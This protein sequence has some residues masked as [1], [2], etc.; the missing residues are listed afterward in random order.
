ME[1]CNLTITRRC[2]VPEKTQARW[3]AGAAATGA[4]LGSSEEWAVINALKAITAPETTIGLDAPEI[5][6]A[7]GVLPP[8]TSHV[9]IWRGNPHWTLNGRETLARYV[10]VPNELGPVLVE[11]YGDAEKMAEI[12]DP[13][14]RSNA[15][16]GGW[17]WPDDGKTFL[18]YA[19]WEREIFVVTD[20][21]GESQRMIGLQE[22]PTAAA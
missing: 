15:M 12:S 3:R 18:A 13:L 11:F 16:L 21:R 19:D 4:A 22:I 2:P 20:L 5:E 6:F 10:F 17:H 8:D 1:R 14:G 9:E 7:L